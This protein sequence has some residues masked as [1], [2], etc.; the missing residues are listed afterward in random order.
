VAG[1]FVAGSAQL[2]QWLVNSART[3]IYTTAQP[4]ALAA[5]VLASLQLIASE[6][7]RRERLQQHV[8]RVR[9]RLADVNFQLMS[10]RT[11][12]QP[13][14]IGRNEQAMLLAAQLKERGYWV[15]IRPPLFPREQPVCA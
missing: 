11:P 1:A 13:I 9:E 4:P 6:P 2:V 7:W 12:I 10:S 14:I 5:A 3:Y 8:S 15:A